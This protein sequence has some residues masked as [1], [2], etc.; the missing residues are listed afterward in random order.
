MTAI[1]KDKACFG[2][3]GAS[4]IILSLL[5]RIGKI[6]S[7]SVGVWSVFSYWCLYCSAQKEE[8]GL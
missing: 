6:A 7:K 3:E 2:I 8:S 5:V 4:L 1:D